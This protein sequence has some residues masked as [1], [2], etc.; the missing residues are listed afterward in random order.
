MGSMPDLE[1]R[2]VQQLTKIKIKQE[3]VL[4]NF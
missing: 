2:E 3:E 4:K 1:E